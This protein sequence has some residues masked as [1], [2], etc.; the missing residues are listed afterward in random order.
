V[1]D[2]ADA[3]AVHALRG[4]NLIV[5]KGQFLSVVGPSG[6]GKTT[7]LFCLGCMTRPTSGN[8]VVC[9]H[10]TSN[11]PDSI[12][13]V[14]RRRHVGF[15]FQRFNLLPN[16]S[17]VQNILLALKFRGGASL[18]AAGQALESV[19]LAGAENRRP[20]E[21]S[22]GEQQRVAVARAI[23]CKPAI[24]LADEPTGNLDTANADQILDIFRHL[25]R[26]SGQTVVM[27]THNE[28]AAR[29]ADRLIRM[30]DGQIIAAT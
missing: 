21:L 7:L 27:V 13:T 6:C 26:H 2:G 10:E 30:E 15:V 24:L 5:E 12:R 20:P 1:Y 8:V 22:M 23:A 19:G 9:G 29:A 17:A 18:E 4:I 11:A 28:R 16:L 25:N 3:K 14:L